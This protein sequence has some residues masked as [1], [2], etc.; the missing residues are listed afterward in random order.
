MG[1]ASL[2]GRPFRIDPTSISWSY[3]AK[4]K[5]V[6]TVGGK[7]VQVFGTDISDMTVSGQFGIGGWQQQAAFLQEMKNLWEEQASSSTQIMPPHRF[8][9]PPKG[10]DFQVYL[11]AYTS[12]DGPTSVVLD[13]KIFNPKWTLTLFIVEDNA[14]LKTIASDLYIARLAK[15]LGWTQNEYNGGFGQGDT[16]VLQDAMLPSPGGPGGGGSGGGNSGGFSTNVN[17]WRSLVSRFFPAQYVNEALQ[18]IQCESEG[19]PNAVNPKVIPGQG[20]ARG[21]FQHMDAFWPSRSAQA[22]Y[23]GKSVF[24][25]EA[26]IATAAWLFMQTETWSHWSCQRVIKR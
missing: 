15:G 10:W 8:M 9:Y 12:P 16:T 1:Q 7:V 13:N 21:L 3:K 20:Q 6:P 4:T 26:N 22:G 19:N 25:P 17:R 23:P 11:K 24:D 18:I 2:G 14:D 5:E